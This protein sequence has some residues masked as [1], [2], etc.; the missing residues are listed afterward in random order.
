MC[1]S[2]ASSCP[3]GYYPD[4]LT[5]RAGV[6]DEGYDVC[7]PCD[8]LCSTCVGPGVS[9]SSC[10]TCAIAEDEDGMC[11]EACSPGSGQKRVAV[12]SKLLLL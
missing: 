2:S 9:S 6:L 8:R 5:S 10:L 1:L 12:L 3:D 11:V 7:L 4:Q